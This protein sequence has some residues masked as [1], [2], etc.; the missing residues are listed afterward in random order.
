MQSKNSVIITLFVFV[1]VVVSE[2][3]TPCLNFSTDVIQGDISV[4][5]KLAGRIADANAR[6]GQV[7]SKREQEV[8]PVVESR[9]LGAVSFQPRA[10]SLNGFTIYNGSIYTLSP[11]GKLMAYNLPNLSRLGVERSLEIGSVTPVGL[12]STEALGGSQQGQRII[13][14]DVSAE[15]VWFVG[16]SRGKHGIGLARHKSLDVEFSETIDLK[17]P[18][19]GIKMIS[20]SGVLLLANGLGGITRFDTNS[21]RALGSSKI[22]L[23]VPYKAWFGGQTI[24]LDVFNLSSVH[25]G[26]VQVQFYSPQLRKLGVV[27]VPVNDLV[28][29][30]TLTLTI[31]REGFNQRLSEETHAPSLGASYFEGPKF[32]NLR[33]IKNRDAAFSHEHYLLLSSSEFVIGGSL[34]VGMVRFEGDLGYML[35]TESGQRVRFNIPERS[36]SARTRVDPRTGLVATAPSYDKHGL[37]G[38]YLSFVPEFQ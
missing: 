5:G 27:W 8:G 23:S 26:R 36:Y 3:A 20:G 37:N 38:I 21:K 32:L 35:S 24:K 4:N 13:A 12:E 2:A 19:T 10:D 16:E 1:G 11:T 7:Q 33:S 18:V 34:S 28:G 15:G 17:G 6:R 30:E 9:H 14:F 29:G 25:N 22:N 31:S